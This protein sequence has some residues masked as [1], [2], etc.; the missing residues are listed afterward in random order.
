MASMSAVATVRTVDIVV[1]SCVRGGVFCHNRV[2]SRR[3]VVMNATII[4]LCVTCAL[5]LPSLGQS[6]QPRPH[7]Q[8]PPSS[9]AARDLLGNAVDLAGRDRIDE[10]VAAVR[11]AIALAPDFLDA[12]VRYIRLR[13]D[14]QGEPDAVKSEYADLMG[15]QPDNP[16]YPLAL[17]LGGVGRGP[18]DML[19]LKR[20]VALAPDSSWGHFAQSYVVLG[21]T[22]EMMNEEFEGKGPRLVEE[23]L[24]A[25][26][27]PAGRGV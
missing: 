3:L 26:G 11:R 2:E 24:R 8:T 27:G 7:G 23:A 15:R 17:F 6:V 20:V 12:H 10:A 14:F 25:R 19:W 4:A 18:D 13:A 22:W 1:F 9:R 5:A 21:R 16:I